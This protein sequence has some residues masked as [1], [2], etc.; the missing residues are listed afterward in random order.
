[1]QRGAAVLA[2]VVSASVKARMLP[3][4]SLWAQQS[5]RSS[6]RE[7]TAAVRPIFPIL[8]FGLIQ[9]FGHN[10]EG[11][12]TSA[13]VITDP[14]DTEVCAHRKHTSVQASCAAVQP[15]TRPSWPAGARPTWRSGAW[16]TSRQDRRQHRRRHHRRQHRRQHHLHHRHHTVL[17]QKQ[18]AQ[19]T[20]TAT[21]L[22]CTATPINFTAVLM[23]F[24]RTVTGLCTCLATHLGGKL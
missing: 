10:G 3:L 16:L 5:Q 6:V 22:V 17:R 7:K 11:G 21:R 15:A 9:R 4:S 18:R 8:A 20:K 12:P 24:F 2:P 19:P 14:Q 13:W 23:H 1:M